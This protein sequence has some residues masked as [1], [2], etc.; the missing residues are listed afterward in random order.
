MRQVFEDFTLWRTRRFVPLPDSVSL[1]I[2]SPGLFL[3]NPHRHDVRDPEDAVLIGEEAF[4]GHKGGGDR[5]V[6]LR[7]FKE[8]Q[9]RLGEGQSLADYQAGKP[10]P[11]TIWKPTP[12]DAAMWERAKAGMEKLA[13]ALKLYHE[14]C[15][16]YPESLDELRDYFTRGLLPQDPFAGGYF[17]YR[18]TESGFEL[19]CY[20]AGDVPGGEAIPERDIVITERD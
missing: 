3:L 4:M 5:E 11:E 20:G 19:T 8:A 12:E 16:E 6:F 10:A 18:R 2:I 13:K 17:R 9:T 1:F 14:D 7:L 15:D